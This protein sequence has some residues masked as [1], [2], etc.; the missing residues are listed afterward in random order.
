MSDAIDAPDADFD[1]GFTAEAPIPTTTPDT[2]AHEAMLPSEAAAPAAPAPRMAQITEDQYQDLV[3]RAGE[4]DSVKAESKKQFDTAFGKLGGMQQLIDRLQATTQ[5]GQRVQVTA[6]DFEELMAEG[7]PDLA[8]M[9]A[10]G[11]NRILAKMQGTGQPTEINPDRV[12]EIFDQRIGP[13]R[14]A[15]KQELREEFAHNTLT[16]L[17]DDWNAVV[18]SAEFQKW[19]AANK[20]GEKKDRAGTAF[21]YSIDPHFIAK[22]ISDFKAQ[23]KAATVQ[24]SRIAAAV[25]PRGS[26]GHAPARDDDDEFNAGFRS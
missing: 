3:K 25:T 26:G 20:I 8:D 22:H 9:Q 5:P 11:L 13:Q 18:P 10:A 12:G 19:V 15:I 7:Y 24:Q 4:I 16:H 2:S 23:R 6:A 17:H 1:S 14:D 21:E